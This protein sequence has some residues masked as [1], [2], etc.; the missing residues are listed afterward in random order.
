MNRKSIPESV[1]VLGSGHPPPN[2][3]KGDFSALHFFHVENRPFFGPNWHCRL[4]ETIENKGNLV[5][6]LVMESAISGPSE[7]VKCVK[8]TPEKCKAEAVFR[9]GRPRASEVMKSARPGRKSGLPPELR[10][11]GRDRREGFRHVGRMSLPVLHRCR[12]GLLDGFHH[13]QNRVVSA[14]PDVQDHRSPAPPVQRQFHRPGHIRDVGEV[15]PLAPVA[16][17]HQRLARRDPAGERIQSQV[18]ALAFL[19]IT[20]KSQTEKNRNATNRRPCTRA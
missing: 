3:E 1:P 18:G 20:Q 12:C 10:P 15:A 6:C 13:V 9:A 11:D 8:Q 5:F 16:V 19:L 17:D 14:R 7:G 2:H 4:A